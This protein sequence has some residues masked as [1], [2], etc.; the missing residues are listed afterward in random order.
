MIKCLSQDGWFQ[1]GGKAAVLFNQRKLKRR[2]WPSS[3][4]TITYGGGVTVSPEGLSTAKI[5]CWLNLTR[6]WIKMLNQVATVAVYSCFEE[7]KGQ[8]G[9]LVPVNKAWN[10]LECQLT[11]PS[12]GYC[13]PALTSIVT[14]LTSR[15][16]RMRAQ[17]TFLPV[18]G[19]L[20]AQI[21]IKWMVY[22]MDTVAKKTFGF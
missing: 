3:H 4:F 8:F 9:I 22:V 1:W 6:I 2:Q 20:F 18:C 10:S 13:W 15:G 21:R 16:Y 17:Q 19:A 12:A 7:Q 5:K 11:K 14:T